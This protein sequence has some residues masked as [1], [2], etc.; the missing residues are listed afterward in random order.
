MI[1]Y[2]KTDILA[3]YRNLM[4]TAIK[5][6][7][8]ANWKKCID[9]LS[10][11]ANWAYQFNFLYTDEAAESLIMRICDRTV[12]HVEINFPDKDKFVLIDSFCMDNRGLT[13]QYL[14]AM[15]HHKAE[16]LYIC[17]SRYLG[18]G[19]DILKELNDYPKARVLLFDKDCSDSIIIAS[20]VSER[21]ESYC[22]GHL[23]MHI[24]PWDVAALV[25]CCAISGVVKYNINLTDHA[26]WMGAE[27]IDY[28]IEFRP[29]GMTVSLEK[30]GLEPNQCL[31]LP[32]YPI[33]PLL[34]VFEGFPD[35]P[36]D[37]VR[38]FT[39]GALYKILGKKDIFFR[40]MERLLAI[41]PNIYI[42]VAGF[43]HDKLFD[44]KIA[45]LE[46]GERILQIGV[47]KDIDAVFDYCDIYLGTYPMTGGLMVQYAAKHAKP[48]VAY[49]EE[50]D[51]MNVVEEF[52]N[53]YQH[54]YHSFSD[55]DEMI[56]YAEKLVKDLDY[57]Q[58]E[59]KLLQIGMMNANH[60]NTEFHDMVTAHQTSFEWQKDKIDYNSF[61]Q[62]YLDL[63]NNGGFRATKDLV[64]RHKLNSL[65]ALKGYRINA[66][67]SMFDIALSKVNNRLRKR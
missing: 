4:E 65:M 49:H 34:S 21:V 18:N 46:G 37:A 61:F 31:S 55:I 48:V 27:F 20:K 25:S 41:A 58:R 8:K 56:S 39:G 63:E 26:Y 50:G 60:F 36:H 17:T 19:G 38:V 10:S 35:L 13:Q 57:R 5:Y 44:D 6:S 30:R 40:I 32:F 43:A 53:Y 42:L 9:Y 12:P 51:V 66:L 22:P 28:N 3:I 33:S 29:Y 59:G 67:C 1:P 64:L 24:A 54:E 14:R 23:F 52:L 11:A 16:I 62:R 2:Q 47:R 45:T 15:M 7:E